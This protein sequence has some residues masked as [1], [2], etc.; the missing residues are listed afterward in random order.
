M[1][2]TVPLQF[3]GITVS[4]DLADVTIYTDRYG[5]KTAYP[6]APPKCPPSERQV[7]QRARFAAAITDWRDLAIAI[8]LN[9]E[10]ASLRSSIC[11]TGHNLYIHF[12]LVQHDGVRK[13]LERQTGITL[14]APIPR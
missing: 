1:A 3:M 10:L 4:G 14:P 9:W 13:T 5:R 2:F 6:K 8:R 12:A 7:I 11:M